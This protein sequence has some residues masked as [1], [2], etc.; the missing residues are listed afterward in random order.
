MWSVMMF[1]EVS[2]LP[3]VSCLMLP[4]THLTVYLSKK[5]WLS[6][7]NTLGLHD[8]IYVLK[9]ICPLSWTFLV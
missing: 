2:K 6:R 5:V 4:M 8:G 1:V 9:I 7:S 3:R